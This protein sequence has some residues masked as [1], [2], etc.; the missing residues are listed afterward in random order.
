MLRRTEALG[1]ALI[2]VPA[3]AAALALTIVLTVGLALVARLPLAAPLGE[4]VS[5]AGALLL[6]PR[7]KET[8][9]L[10]LPLADPAKVE[11]GPPLELPLALLAAEEE[12]LLQ[13]VALGVP[14]RLCGD[15][16]P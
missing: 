11:E 13:A 2:V 1:G 16:V 10:S 15:S 7:L 4:A 5:D 8:L 14:L 9:L 3:D 12:A 6:P